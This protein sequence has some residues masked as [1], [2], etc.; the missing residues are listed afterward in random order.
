MKQNNIVI[1]YSEY[2]DESKLS[3]QDKKLISKAKEAAITAYAPYSNFKVGAS[4]LLEN[5]EIIT[6]NNQENAAYPSG[7]CAERVAL[8]YANANFP[9][10][11]VIAMA[12]CAS[13]KNGFTK[14]PVP[15]CGSCRQVLLESELRFKKPIKLIMIGDSKL[16]VIENTQQL[17]PF[18]FEKDF[19]SE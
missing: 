11:P 10:T 19:L 6:G 9:K 5:G 3:F 15:P 8:F 7:L 14:L 1:N 17:L 16:I 13:T 2:N 18:H 4:L 12:I